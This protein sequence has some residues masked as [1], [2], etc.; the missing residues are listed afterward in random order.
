MRSS[1]VSL[2]SVTLAPRTSCTVSVNVTGTASGVE[3]N[4]VQATSTHEGAGNISNASITV[5]TP[6]TISKAFNRYDFFSFVC[7]SMKKIPNVLLHIF[8]SIKK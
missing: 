8:P 2:S 7:S 5:L 3:N 4:S 6:P 1:S